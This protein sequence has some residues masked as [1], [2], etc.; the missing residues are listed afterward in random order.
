MSD[1][2]TGRYRGDTL[3]SVA[4]HAVLMGD[5]LPARDEV[6]DLAQHIGVALG[7]LHACVRKA[8]T[9]QQADLA[10]RELLD[11]LR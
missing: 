11:A 4:A 7:T 5:H 1:N 3:S 8:R 2:Y 9:E 6:F 10:V